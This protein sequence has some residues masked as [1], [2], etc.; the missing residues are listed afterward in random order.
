MN[1]FLNHSFDKFPELQN[2]KINYEK[3]KNKKKQIPQKSQR[4]FSL[5]NKPYHRMILLDIFSDASTS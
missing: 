1:T 2:K 5:W 3:E 4:I